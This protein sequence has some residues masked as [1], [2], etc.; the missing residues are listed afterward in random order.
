MD[1]IGT[2]Y[3]GMFGDLYHT[4]VLELAADI[5]HVG[6]LDDPHGSCLKVSRICGSSVHVDVR[7]DGA[8][9]ITAIAFDPKACALGQAA[10]SILARRAPGRSIEEIRAAREA[11]FAMLKDGAEPPS[12]DFW[13]LRHLAAVRDYPPRHVS[14]LL[15]FDAL[16]E[17]MTMALER[18]GVAP[19]AQT[20]EAQT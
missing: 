12:G 8:G 14:T 16:L 11:L 2:T 17:A 6:R 18:T 15:A 13:E 9:R 5:P 3:T 19:Q 1:R 20:P 4:R 7:L 10:T